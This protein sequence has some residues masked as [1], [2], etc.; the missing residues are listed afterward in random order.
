MRLLIIEQAGI[1]NDPLG[2]ILKQ[3]NNSVDVVPHGS[4]VMELLSVNKYDIIIFQYAN[5][6][7]LSIIQAIRN[8]GNTTPALIM[9][10]VGGSDYCVQALDSGADDYLCQ[11]CD[12][13]ELL[14]RIRALHRRD[15]E[16]YHY[17]EYKMGGCV[18]LPTQC[19]IR[20]D[21]EMVWLTLKE[22]MILEYLIRNEN[23]VVTKEQLLQRIWGYNCDIEYNN[24]EVNISHLR[25]KLAPLKIRAYIQTVRGIGYRFTERKETMYVHTL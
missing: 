15:S 24:I 20:R 23:Q 22:S 8:R 14:A 19:M 5:D 1:S 25:K 21:E 12:I 2:R 17:D 6:A 3:R 18:F 13:E 7:Y 10:A 4:Q 16:V 11:P 9:S